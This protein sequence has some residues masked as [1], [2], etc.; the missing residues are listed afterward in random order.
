MIDD[1]S[2]YEETTVAA[3][4]AFGLRSAGDRRYEAMRSAAEAAVLRHVSEAGEL[5]LTSEATPVSER[6][7]Y[8]TR[9]FGTFPW[10]QGPLLL[11][12]CQLA[13]SNEP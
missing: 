12:L 7:V 2:T 6:H 10:G 8:A 1:D 3:M 13:R 9:C 5:L 11:L 4:L